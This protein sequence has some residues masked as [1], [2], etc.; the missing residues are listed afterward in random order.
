VKDRDDQDRGRLL[1]AYNRQR[2]APASRARR[3]TRPNKM[4]GSARRTS[5]REERRD[6]IYASLRR[7]AALMPEGEGKVHRMGA[8]GPGGKTAV[9][10]RATRLQGPSG[11]RHGLSAGRACHPAPRR[12]RPRQVKAPRSPS[13][14][15]RRRDRH[16][17]GGRL[18]G[19]PAEG[20]TVNAHHITLRAS[21]SIVVSSGWE[22]GSPETAHGAW[23]SKEDG[24]GEP[25][26]QQGTPWYPSKGGHAHPFVA[27]PRTALRASSG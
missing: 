23:Q 4:A 22:R 27:I 7:D 8:N 25:R 18:G 3:P 5:K 24:S 9:T 12:G 14:E 1:E 10:P 6:K 21:E 11:R 16:G 19:D 26:S 13:R 15:R 20:V 17:G 2:D